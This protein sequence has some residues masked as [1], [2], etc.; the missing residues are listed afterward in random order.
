MGAKLDLKDKEIAATY[1]NQILKTVHASARDNDCYY[2]EK[3]KSFKAYEDFKWVICIRAC[4]P[5][6]GES[7]GTF[8]MVQLAEVIDEKIV[9]QWFSSDFDGLVKDIIGTAYEQLVIPQRGKIIHILEILFNY[10]YYLHIERNL[11]KEFIF[12]NHQECGSQYG[13]ILV[14]KTSKIPENY[15]YFKPGLITF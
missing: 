6:A 5:G 9:L 3:T 11:E 10:N 15:H 2:D 14:F 8:E 13:E 1:F 4:G 7:L 12:L